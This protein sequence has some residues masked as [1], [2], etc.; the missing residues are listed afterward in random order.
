MAH[1][2]IFAMLGTVSVCLIRSLMRSLP[3]NLKQDLEE[4]QSLETGQ[5]GG[6]WMPFTG[7]GDNRPGPRFR[8]KTIYPG[9]VFSTH[10][11][12]GSETLSLSWESLLVRHCLCHI[13]STS[14]ISGQCP[15]GKAVI[16]S[17]ILSANNHDIK[18]PCLKNSG[19]SLAWYE[20]CDLKWTGENCEIETVWYDLTFIPK[21]I[22][23]MLGW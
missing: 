21:M 18:A 23:T 4:R 22:R 19:T 17:L 20:T 16:G 8:I 15:G 14:I 10:R 3:M 11:Y 2:L 1:G 7:P 12:D 6:Y 5:G 13:E 9:E